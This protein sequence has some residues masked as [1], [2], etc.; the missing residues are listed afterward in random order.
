MRI[1]EII[2]SRRWVNKV[3]GQTA[4]LHGSI[5]FGINDVNHNWVIETAGY[6]WRLDN[7]TIGL[8]RSPAKTKDEALAVAERF[9]ARE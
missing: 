5:P 6:T 9:N 4:S 8:G 2:E 7:G 3:T 1:V